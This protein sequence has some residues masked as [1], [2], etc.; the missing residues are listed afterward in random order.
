MGTLY[1]LNQEYM[2]LLQQI[3]EAGAEELEGLF[4][5]L[6]QVGGSLTEKAVN[7]AKAMRNLTADADAMRAEAA[8]LTEAA[9][10]KE[11]TVTALKSRILYV[12]H[13]NGL[14]TLETPI[15]KWAIRRSP[16]SVE[17]INADAIPAEYRIPQP[18]RIDKAAIK[19]AYTKG[20][21]I[22]PGAEIRQD[23][24]LMFR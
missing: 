1:E 16:L 13:E 5:R 4:E 23:D 9:R 2:N 10:R 7:Y 17:I 18:D 21:E 20:G 12:M 8:R 6:E 24:C 19:A 14:K 15:G 11:T 3:D 22:V